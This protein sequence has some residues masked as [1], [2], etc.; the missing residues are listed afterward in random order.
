MRTLTTLL[1]AVA[2][3]APPAL[4]A[5]GHHPCAAAR[6]HPGE[7][8]TATLTTDDGRRFEIRLDEGK[9]FTVKDLDSGETVCDLDLRELREEIEDA[10]AEAVAGA[11]EALAALQEV[12]VDVHL[13]EGEHRLHVAS[14]DRDVTIDLDAALAGLREAMHALADDRHDE[15]RQVVALQKQIQELQRQI[16]E[17]E[18]ELT[19]MR[20]RARH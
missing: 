6:H 16:D 12:A 13:G 14:G 5:A 4:A 9:S 3:L 17:L 18:K 11:G 1:L 7:S 20:R 8:H 10:V 19:R 2:L 15:D